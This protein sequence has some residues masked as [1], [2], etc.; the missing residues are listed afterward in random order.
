MSQA[1]SLYLDLTVTEN[2]ELFAGVY[3]LDSR[4]T[5]RRLAWI[6]RMA[7][8]TGYERE[9]TSRL[10]MG[11]RQRLALGCALV[12]RPPVLFLDEPTSGVDPIGRR[13]FW[14]ILG[15]LAREQRVAILATTHYMSEAEHC[16]RLALMHAGRIVSAGSPLD[17]KETLARDAGTLLQITTNAPAAALA[18]LRKTGRPGVALHGRRV[19]VFSR[20]PD[21]EQEIRRQLAT[22]G[23]IVSDV[24]AGAITLEDV[25]VYRV[26]ERERHAGA[27][28]AA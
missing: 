10:P 23:V 28:A 19:H 6:V 2:I 15:R 20:R 11:V 3:G 5:R 8:L 16:D 7:G 9:L 26:M 14:A 12:H 1:F 27:E 25:F 4:E 22:A 21:D 24:R 17:M 18:E 13:R